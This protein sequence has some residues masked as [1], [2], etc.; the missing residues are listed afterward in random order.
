LASLGVDAVQSCFMLGPAWVDVEF[1]LVF[2]WGN[3][4]DASLSLLAVLWEGS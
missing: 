3:D 1:S 4:V 2:A